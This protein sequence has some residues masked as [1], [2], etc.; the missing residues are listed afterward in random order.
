MSKNEKLAEIVISPLYQRIT[1]SDE[2][3]ELVFKILDEVFLPTDTIDIFCLHCRKH[4]IFKLVKK[5]QIEHNSYATSVELQ[6]Q[7]I[8]FGIIH[9]A[10]TRNTSH[11]LG[12]IFILGKNELL[13]IGQYPS[14]ADIEFPDW[15]KYSEIIPAKVLQDIKRAC[16]LASHGIGAG[17]YVYLRRAIEYLLNNAIKHA[18]DQKIFKEDD[19]KGLRVIEKIEKLKD[20]LPKILFE[21]KE[22]Y[23]ILSKGV[24]ELSEEDCL[25]SFELIQSTIQLILDE[26]LS[27]KL[28]NEKEKI[29]RKNIAETHQKMK[30]T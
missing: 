8:P 6:N 27:E 16:G 13:K 1:L 12:V 21:N 25:S 14:K 18:I 9:F 30:K 10:C 24:H 20:F 26:I 22:A 15:D 2:D 4:S 11:Y 5:G 29:I 23:S 19:F 28:K 7:Q 17:S 3:L